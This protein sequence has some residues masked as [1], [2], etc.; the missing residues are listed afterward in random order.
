MQFSIPQ[1]LQ[2]MTSV[3]NSVADPLRKPL[4]EENCLTLE[5][6]LLKLCTRR[7]GSNCPPL[8]EQFAAQ[9]WRDAALL[10]SNI[11]AGVLDA[12]EAVAAVH[13]ASA[14]SSPGEPS[15]VMLRFTERLPVIG[16]ARP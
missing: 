10:S 11:Y 7:G 3:D 13:A 14:Q 12:M 6:C 16:I 9:G 5:Q 2:Q 4:I 15:T 8:T 1:R